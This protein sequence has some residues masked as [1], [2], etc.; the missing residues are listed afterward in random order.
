MRSDIS[1]HVFAQ[2]PPPAERDRDI[3]P[4]R[5]PLDTLQLCQIVSDC[6][7]INTK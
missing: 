6:H 4:L 1:S 3:F 5:P 2:A 7:Q